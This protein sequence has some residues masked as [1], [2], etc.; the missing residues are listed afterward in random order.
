MS[1]R[2]KELEPTPIFAELS[3]EFDLERL[4]AEPAE[5]DKGAEQAE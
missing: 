5:P 3:A 4:L 2:Q 1:V